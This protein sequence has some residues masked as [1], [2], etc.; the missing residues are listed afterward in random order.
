MDNVI[1][2]PEDMINLIRRS[3]EISNK[4]G[5]THILSITEQQDRAFDEGARHNRRQQHQYYDRRDKR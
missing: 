5:Y 3:V 4:Q 1:K 2:T